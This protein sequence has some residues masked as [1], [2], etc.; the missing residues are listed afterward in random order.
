MTNIEYIKESVTIGM[1]LNLYGIEIN[2]ANFAICP[3]HKDKHPS[4]KVYL[5]SNTYHCFTCHAHGDV[6]QLVRDIQNCDLQTAISILCKEFNLQEYKKPTYYQ[7]KEIQIK[8]LEQLD[9]ITTKDKENELFCNMAKYSQMAYNI[10]DN[11][12]CLLNDNN[13]NDFLLEQYMWWKSYSSYLTYL[14]FILTERS[15]PNMYPYPVFEALY[16]YRKFE[17]KQKIKLGLLPYTY[18]DYCKSNIYKLGLV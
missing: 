3:I 11:I 8:K 4:M 13:D 17:V 10:V 5:K 12:N 6:I 9:Y 18:Y 16:G 2:Q 14:F 15:M 7:V 1:V